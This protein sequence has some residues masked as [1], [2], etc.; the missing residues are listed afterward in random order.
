MGILDEQRE[1]PLD[2]PER[3]QITDALGRILASDDFI[4]SGRNRRF[5]SYVVEETLAGRAERLKGYTIAVQVFGRDASF[6]AQ[7]DPLVRIEARRLRQ[8]L[9]RYY[10]TAGVADPVRILLPKGGYVPAFENVTCLQAQALRSEQPEPDNSRHDSPTGR[11]KRL[12]LLAL[13]AAAA[14]TMAIVAV[15]HLG[16][17]D[18]PAPPQNEL[19]S[20]G[21]SVLVQSFAPVEGTAAEDRFRVGLTDQV[22]DALQRFKT[23]RIVPA[24]QAEAGAGSPSGDVKGQSQASTDYTLKGS[25]RALDETVRI[26]VQL[27]ESG[28]GVLLWTHVFE[29]DAKQDN[30]FEIQSEIASDVAETLGDPYDLLF[31]NELKKAQAPGSAV[32]EIYTCVLRFYQ[33]W[34]NPRAAEHLSLRNCHERSVSSA[35]LNAGVLTNLAW[36]YLDEYRFDFNRTD[37]LDP[38]LERAAE[39]ARRAV[40]LQP[41]SARAHLVVA[42]IQWFRKDFRSFDRHAELALSLNPNDSSVNAELGLRYGL[43]GDWERSRPLIDRAISRDPIRWQTYRVSYAQHAL[44]N[45]EFERALEELRLTKMSDH[46]ALKVVRAAI[47]GHL[48]R[49]EESQENWN[50]AVRE[51]PQLGSDPRAWID[52]RSPSPLLHRRILEGLEKAG[53]LEAE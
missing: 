6:D 22:T 37:A 19:A 53:L 13:A 40:S 36:L 47:Y 50:A 18:V 33:Y 29:R 42:V 3:E 12:F 24:R 34:L 17:H 4:A 16:E 43:R 48:N 14:A 15:D 9:E 26:V 25:V 39:V 28:S 27:E 45:G 38:P 49:F 32:S 44:E 23:I 20:T 5:L 7:T 35:P 8:S 30:P 46:P 21:P 2:S 31:S 51:M 41:D 1:R 11:V 10:L 52:A